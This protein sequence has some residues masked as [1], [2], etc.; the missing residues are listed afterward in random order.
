MIQTSQDLLI[1]ILS[2]GLGLFFLM[3]S[4]FVA[5]LI[6]LF[7]SMKRLSLKSEELMEHFNN[8]VS[9]PATLLLTALQYL[10]KKDHD[11]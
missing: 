4:V 11:E 9:L 8:Y 5:V 2:V 10:K 7:L 6:G 3:C 1:V